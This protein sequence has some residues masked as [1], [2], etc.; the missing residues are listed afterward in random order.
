VTASG[1][2]AGDGP[3]A[4]G[5]PSPLDAVPDMRTSAMWILGAVAA[6]GAALLG[7]GPLIA[8][9]KIHSYDEAFSAFGGLALGLVGV[10][11]A[12]WHVAEAL[13]PPLTIMS[14][15]D[16]EP[17]LADLRKRIAQQPSAYY[18]PFGTSMAD[19]ETKL[20]FNRAVAAN[21]ADALETEHDKS[22]R[23]VLR[24]AG[25]SAEV[26][27]AAIQ[28]RMQNM[29]ELAHAWRVRA[30]LRRARL[31]AFVGGAVAVVGALIFSVVTSGLTLR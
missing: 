23:R 25:E 18:G 1:T 28:R 24:R 12:I 7:G 13:I 9:G 16:T 17:L 20:A 19:L 11:W 5:L 31:H 6:V 8:V 21:I 26:T 14:S 30:E 3:G 2:R 10:G 27:V 29:L 15:L 22:K 4:T